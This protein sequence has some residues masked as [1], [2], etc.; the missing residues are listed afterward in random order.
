MKRLF[1]PTSEITELL[2]RSGNYK[3][4]EDALDAQQIIADSLAVPL[5]HTE[6]QHYGVLPFSRKQKHFVAHVDWQLKYSLDA[7]WDICARAIEVLQ[8]S[9]H[10][11]LKKLKDKG[12]FSIEVYSDAEAWEEHPKRC[13]FFALVNY[14]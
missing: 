4:C 11:R 10:T 1:K 9:I 13:R 8:D 12:V 5:K 3:D 6:E 7:R 2:V 14:G